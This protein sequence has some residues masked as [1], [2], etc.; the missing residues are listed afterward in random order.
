MLMARG[1]EIWL[2][3][4]GLLVIS[5]IAGLADVDAITLSVASIVHAGQIVTSIATTA[6]LAAAAVN[7][8]TKAALVVAI[9]KSRMGLYVTAPL[10]AALAAG[11]VALWLGR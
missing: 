11:A 1:F 7:T 5:A 9:T 6:I 2:W 3:N 10:L 4:R 8:L